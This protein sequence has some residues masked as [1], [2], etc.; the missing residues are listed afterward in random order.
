MNFRKA[1]AVLSVLML[2]MAM[3]F[4]GGSSEASSDIHYS[5]AVVNTFPSTVFKISL[6]SVYDDMINSVL[7]I[8]FANGCQEDFI[9]CL[10][11][12]SDLLAKQ[13]QNSEISGG[14]GQKA[15]RQPNLDPA[16]TEW[17]GR[18]TVF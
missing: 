18:M 3:A 1:M 17:V 12:L 13:N 6:G 16:A 9:F 5:I 11:L 14:P 10:I 2:S 15:G 8:N 7:C 4:A